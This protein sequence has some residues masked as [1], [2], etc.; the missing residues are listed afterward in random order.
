MIDRRLI[1]RRDEGVPLPNM[2]DQ[3]IVSVIN[4]AH[5]HREAPAHFQMMNAKPISKRAIT[6]I[7]NQN[8]MAAMALTYHEVNMIAAHMVDKGVIDVEENESWE[9]QEVNPVHL[10]R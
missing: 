2:M 7:T 5:F 8:L 9:M 10:V 3:E 1:S 4:K 6:A